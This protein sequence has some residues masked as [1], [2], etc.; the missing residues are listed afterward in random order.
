MFGDR[1]HVIVDD[2]GEGRARI[3]SILSAGGIPVLKERIVPPSLEN[4]FISIVNAAQEKAGTGG[5]G[6]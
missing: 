1:L 6:E 3:R 2:P 5:E 4:V